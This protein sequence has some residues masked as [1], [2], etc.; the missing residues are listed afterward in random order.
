LTD[1]LVVV[2]YLILIYSHT[3][4]LWGYFIILSFKLKKGL[5]EKANDTQKI[6]EMKNEFLT[7]SKRPQ[8]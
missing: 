6:Q 4:T 3:T 5:K 1:D 2:V 8:R 7:Y